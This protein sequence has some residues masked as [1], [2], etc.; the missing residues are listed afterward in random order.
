M[1]AKNYL[2]LV[3][4]KNYNKSEELEKLDNKWLIINEK[5]NKNFK[6]KIFLSRYL[7]LYVY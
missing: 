6:D 3:A 1:K 7:S 4:M 2:I 5:K